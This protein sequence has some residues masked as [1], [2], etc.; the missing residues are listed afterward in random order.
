MSTI[1]DPDTGGFR[2]SQ[3]LSDTRYRAFTF[4]AIALLLLIAAFS[5][6]GY[7]LVSN[8][9]AAGLNISF[10]FLDEAAGYDVGQALIPYDSQSSNWQ[11]AKV[12]ILNTLLVAVL[13][14]IMATIFGVIAGVL[15]LS[16]NWIVS[17][18][19]AAYVEAFRN[20]PVLIWILIIYA[21]MTVS[22]PAPSAFRGETPD[23]TMLMGLIA[24]TNRGI[25]IPAPVW[26]PGSMVVVVTFILSII[27]AF[28]YRAY[29]KKLL[30]DTGKL[31]PMGWPTVAIIFVPAILMF[32]ILGRPI[33]LDIP[34][35]SGFNFGGGI[36]I[37]APLIALWFALS[38]YTGAF[39][40]ENVRAGIQAVSHGQTEAA[41][42]LGLRPRRI[43]NL[44]VLPQALR[45]I[46]PPLI[47]QYLNL[48]K[49]S[50]LAIA[51][52]YADVTA[53]L[54]GITLNQTGRAIECVLL[55][56]LFYLAISLSISAIMNVYNNSVKLKER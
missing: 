35:L 32:F 41:A 38:I 22:L 15:R 56:M 3:L 42:A 5:Y 29:A 7:N 17:R 36:K 9:R 24:F 31:L 27:A 52:G 51:V 46:I 23:S 21:I 49:N 12:G 26:N 2:V 40:A 53:T 55:L 39:I 28:A 4:Q 6:L 48:T 45:V 13:G 16:K 44:V 11:A 54:G 30:F 1:T 34:V 18:L 43:M 14:C 20:V 10:G 19:M 8:L 25:Y 50:S 47:S 37:G 33:G